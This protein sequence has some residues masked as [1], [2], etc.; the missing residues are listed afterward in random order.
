MA[1]WDDEVLAQRLT[2]ECP[3]VVHLVNQRGHLS[4][5]ST[6]V[7]SADQVMQKKDVLFRFIM[8][9]RDR[10]KSGQ[11]CLMSNQINQ[12]QVKI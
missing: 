6:V 12:F 2:K 10:T 5:Q 9:A 3:R 11:Y 8:K 1:T 7:F 4:T